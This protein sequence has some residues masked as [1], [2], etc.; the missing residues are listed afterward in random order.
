MPFAPAVLSQGS[1]S[2]EY[3][4]TG[5]GPG[6]VLVHG[7]FAHAEANWAAVTEAIADRYTVVA[8]NLAGSGAT[9]HPD[10]VT[11]DD[12]AAQVLAAADHAG[13]E[14]F[15]VVGHSL[16]A[17][18]AATLAAHHPD[19]VD[20]LVL[21]A[22]WV[23]TDARGAALFDLWDSLLRT[24]PTLLAQLL[25]LTVLRPEVTAA[26]SEAEFADCVA[27]FA[28]LLDIRHTVQ[29]AADR[30]TDLRDLLPRISAPTLVL[31]SG[32]DQVVD[33]AAQRAVALAIPAA[34]Y[35]EFDAGHAL[36]VED[37]AGFTRA[38]SEF[39]DRCAACGVA[40]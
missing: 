30:H 12:M 31:A 40:A 11:V 36:P 19:R 15:Q 10:V 38:I 9:T 28:G 33:I 22:P 18:V 3:L 27:V 17:V 35:R 7:T 1:S 4:V 29:L 23:T 14:T 5:A 25:P 8:P 2:V 34:D 37:C 16:G 24:D 32:Q 6:A 21:H 39:L 13:L 20:G 26:W